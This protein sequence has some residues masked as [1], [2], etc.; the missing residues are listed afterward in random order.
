MG[1]STHI[2]VT[3]TEVQVVSATEIKRQTLRMCVAYHDA[4]HCMKCLSTLKSKFGMCHNKHGL[5]IVL[6]VVLRSLVLCNCVLLEL[7]SSFNTT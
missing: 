3:S 1:S 7:I 6:Q 5:D 4:L 2:H